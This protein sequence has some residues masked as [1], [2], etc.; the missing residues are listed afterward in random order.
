M[1]FLLFLCLLLTTGEARAQQTDDHGGTPADATALTLGTTVTGVISPAGDRDMFTFDIP[2]TV[3]ITDV[4]IYTQ[5]GISDTVGGLF[6]GSGAQ[7]AINDDSALSA[8]TSHFY[9]GA[10]LTPGTYY[11]VVAGH[12]AVTGPYSL[13]T[14]TGTDQGKTRADAAPLPV[15]TQEEGIIGPAEDLDLFKIEL[16]TQADVVM[17]TS[18]NLDTIGRLLDY[19]GVQIASND[20]SSMSEER[21]DFSIGETLGPGVYYVEVSGYDDSTGAYRLH[22]ETVTDQGDNRQ[23]ALDLALDSSELGFINH[24]LDQDYFRLTLPDAAYVWIYAIGPTDTIGELLDSHSSRVAYSDDSELSAGRLS[25]F[26]AK[27]LQAGTYHLKVSGVAGGSGPYRVY[28]TGVPETGGTVET[29]G[30]LEPGTPLIGLIDPS[31]DTNLYKMEITEP[32]EFVVYTTGDLDTTGELLASDGATLTSLTADDDSGTELNFS[33]RQDLGPGTYYVRAGSYESETG[34]YALF[35]EPVGQLS[36]GESVIGRI[37]EGYD[38]EYFK[39]A[40]DRPSDVWIYGFGPLDTVGTLYDSNFNV[41]ASN[42]DSL[43]ISRRRAFHIRES[44]AAGTYYVNVRSYGTD[45]G[46]FGIGA[47]T[48]PDHGNSRDT[49]TALTLNSLVPGRIKHAGDTDYFRLDLTEKTNVIIYG[50]TSTLEPV[51]GEILDSDGERVDVNVSPWDGGFYIRDDFSAGAYFVKVTTDS[52]ADYTLHTRYDPWYTA[53]IDDCRGTTGDPLYVCQWHL[54]NHENDDADINVEPVWANGIDGTGV[55]VA[56][57]DDGID[58]Y[59]E[60]LAPNI[61]ASLNYDYT[62]GGDVHS[63]LEHH[64]TNVAGVIAARDNSVGVRGVA[65]RATIYGYNFLGFTTILNEVD[66][67]IRNRDVTAVNSNS[68]GPRDGPEL[69][70]AEAIWEAAVE[71]GV[72]KGYGGKGIF[73]T[74]A[75]GNG[76]DEGDNSNLDGFT[77]YY[78]TTAVCAVDDNYIRTYYSEAGANLWVCA[79]S[80]GLRAGDRGIVTTENSNRYSNSFNGTSASTPIVAG[81]AALLRQA[82]PEL[83]WR[84]LKLILAGSARKNDEENTGWEDGA[85]KYGSQTERYH[86]NHEYGFGVV[87]A[88]AAVDLAEGWATVPPLESMEVASGYLDAHVPDVPVGGRPTTITQALTLATDIRSTEFVEIDLNFSHPSFRDLEIELVSPSGQVSTLVGPYE[89]EDPVPLFGEFR[90]GSAKHLGEDPNGQWTIRVTD[91]IPGL[92]GTFEAWNIKVYGHRLVPAAPTVNT[93]VLGIDSLTVTWSAPGFMRG[94]DITAYD[95]RYIPT[96]AD[97]TNDS[98]W[99]VIEGVWRTGGGELTAQVTGLAGNTWYDV[100]VRAVNAT[101]PGNWSATATGILNPE[102]VVSWYDANGNGTIEREEVI[103]AINDYLDG[104]ITREQVFMVITAYLD[105]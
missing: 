82:N 102:D 2:D 8:N 89:A 40:V 79:P 55:N 43:L 96:V 100:Q 35:A 29:A 62:G 31:T 98:N 39:L 36:L 87:D 20:D 95:L 83:T 56:V 81:V 104:L 80:H 57:V 25:F 90:F 47:E 64:G 11:V 17:Y 27:N 22:V 15:D 50:K 7:I 97:E 33:I 24:R 3:E 30:T 14:R 28:A 38:E 66:A 4:W 45:V 53:F 44:L 60:D 101:G 23:T 26:I 59:H 74:W 103:A 75:A 13:H 85:L 9:I 72:E 86:F 21:S 1:A 12:E 49:A 70:S 5:G 91:R 77:S 61:D 10:S 54:R 18:G 67:A 93:A 42:D 32:A 92:T 84:D 73:Y 52:A 71:S 76:G 65:P 41:I 88:K 48:I 46:R 6:D 63:P 37:A 99:N 69:Y 34:P 51:A 16:P 94:G 68:W 58:Q 78:A 19:R 105:S